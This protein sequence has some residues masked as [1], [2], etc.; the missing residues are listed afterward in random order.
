MSV[1]KEQVIEILKCIEDP[2]LFL[3]I[4]F[5]GLIRDVRIDGGE[6]DVDMTFTTPLCPSGPMLV[7]QVKCGIETIDG[8]EAVRVHVV[9]D[10]PW[11]P[12]EDVRAMLGM[13]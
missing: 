9:F 10:P 3:D 12:S 5:L 6:V 7:D 13:L 4:W 2:D 1:S 8:V 11:E